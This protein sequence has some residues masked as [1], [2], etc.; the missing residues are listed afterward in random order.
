MMPMQQYA[1]QINCSNDVHAKLIDIARVD[2]RNEL[3]NANIRSYVS[4]NSV[5]N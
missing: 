2:C 5:A 1:A 3:G 4:L